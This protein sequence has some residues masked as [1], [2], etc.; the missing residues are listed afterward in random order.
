MTV[1]TH[2]PS[3]TSVG[4]SMSHSGVNWS[5]SEFVGLS[6][7]SGAWDYNRS[8][9]DAPD[10]SEWIPELLCS[11]HGESLSLLAWQESF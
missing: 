8:S 4:V 5:R 6:N 3:I 9:L 1:T 10:V 11:I 7:L 2:F